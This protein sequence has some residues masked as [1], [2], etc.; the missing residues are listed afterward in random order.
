LDEGLVNQ[1]LALIKA[2]WPSEPAR[3]ALWQLARSAWSA[4]PTEP[5]RL[6]TMLDLALLER[7]LGCRLP[8][9]LLEEARHRAAGT[10]LGGATLPWLERAEIAI[11]AAQLIRSPAGPAPE[12]GYACVIS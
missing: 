1:A 9:Q 10:G 4:S 12:P 2:E 7:Q 3:D 8:E 5:L 6:K 11:M